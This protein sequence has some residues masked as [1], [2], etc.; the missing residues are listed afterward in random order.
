MSLVCKK[1]FGRFLAISKRGLWKMQVRK[2]D[3]LTKKLKETAAKLR[4]T[5]QRLHIMRN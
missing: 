3:K 5:E 4:R 1:I 2:V